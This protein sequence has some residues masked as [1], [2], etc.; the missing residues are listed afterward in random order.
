ME[1]LN[2]RN[3]ALRVSDWRLVVRSSELQLFADSTEPLKHQTRSISAGGRPIDGAGVLPLVLQDPAAFT[4]TA[5]A[6]ASIRLV[7]L[8][9]SRAAFTHTA[10]AAAAASVS[11]SAAPY[12]EKQLLISGYAAGGG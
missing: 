11:C 3:D 6:A 9:L 10:S 12:T 1:N 8:D 7:L 4:Y 5:S 2:L